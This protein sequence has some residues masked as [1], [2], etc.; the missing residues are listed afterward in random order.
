MGVPTFYRWLHDHYPKCVTDYS[1]G[2][3]SMTDSEW[4]PN[5]NGIEVDNFV[6]L[7]AIELAFRLFASRADTPC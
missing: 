4:P 6:L 1:E 7:T 5:G 3:A 2:T